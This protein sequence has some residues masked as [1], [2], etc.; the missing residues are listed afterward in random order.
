MTKHKHNIVLL[1]GDGI[2]P[3]VT[4]AAQLVLAEV[5]DVFGHHFEFSSHDIGGAA[6]DSSGDPLP[7]ATRDACLA[8]DAVFLGAVG[9]PK[10]E[11]APRK[12]EA[13]LLGL[14]KAMGLFANMRPVAAEPFTAAHSPLKAE[15]IRGVDLLIVRELTGGAYFGEKSRTEDQA[16]DNCVYTREE[17]E[18]VAR[19][20]F[21]AAERRRGHVTSV[22]KANVME[23]GR[24]WREVVSRVHADEFPKVKLE[25]ALVDSTAMQLI[26]KP[27]TFDVILTENMFGD[28]LSDEAAVLTGSIG[29]LGSASLGSGGP[30]MFEPI[31][32]SAPDLA[33]SDTANPAGALMSAAMLLRY[34]LGLPAEGDLVEHAVRGVLGSGKVTRD[35]GGAM[36]CSGFA[37]CVAESMRGA[38]WAAMHMGQMHWA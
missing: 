23:T 35:L 5:A 10:W 37:Q 19:V 20:A 14:R 1:P 21:R 32:G 27:R 17:I 36:T 33:G 12:P 8:S 22:D 6:I 34:G 9:G 2:G 15:V 18:R 28:I 24:L 30:A 31:H 16:S 4:A 25:H 38:R 13:G 7:D 11:A 3:E 29:L 26:L